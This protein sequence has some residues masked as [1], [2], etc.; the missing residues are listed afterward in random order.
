MYCEHDTSIS[1]VFLFFYIIV[2]VIHN[3]LYLVYME[4]TSLCIW[5]NKKKKVMIFELSNASSQVQ[6]IWI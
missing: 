6:V 3:I 5:T 1:G 4:S 2:L